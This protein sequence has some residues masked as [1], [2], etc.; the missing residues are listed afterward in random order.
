[1]PGWI[2]TGARG[3][4]KTLA[5][6]AKIKEYALRGRP[7]ATNLDLYLEKLLPLDNTAILYRLPD[8]PALA[9][10][11]L[12]PLAYDRSY[13]GEDMNGLLVLDE[14]GTW[15]NSRSWNDK[16]R[17]A[18]MNWL[19]LSRKYHWDIILL[20]QDYEMIDAQLRNTICEHWV[21]SS[22]LDKVKIPYLAPLLEFIGFNAFMPRIHR[23]F[24]FYGYDSR[25]KP[26]DLWTYS[27]TDFYYGYD[28]NQLFLD[29]SSPA[30][31]HIG[32]S[33]YLPASYLSGHQFITKAQKSLEQLKK[34][35]TKEKEVDMAI[36]KG[37]DNSKIKAYML[38]AFLVAFLAWRFSSGINLKAFSSASP[39]VA[40]PTA[41]TNT[42]PLAAPV[43]SPVSAPSPPL[44]TASAVPVPQSSF[45]QAVVSS[46]SSSA[47]SSPP[48]SA[49]DVANFID[50][51]LQTTRP[52]LSWFVESKVTRDFDGAVEF[53]QNDVL[54]ERFKISELHALGVAM[55]RTPYGFNLLYRTKTYVVPWAMSKPSNPAN[56]HHAQTDRTA[57]KSVSKPKARYPFFPDEDGGESSLVTSD[58]S[59]TP[60]SAHYDFK[61][62][63]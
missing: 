59:S 56:Q 62:H 23:Y 53:Y 36:K 42:T 51:L 22:R 1:M 31:V 19:F 25:Q 9:D 24:V 54:V 8:K 21:V 38:V 44:P 5:A 17:L 29:P 33:T 41:P 28:T 37:V 52:R 57:V 14:L 46:A 12:L 4:G 43:S 16:T 50:D 7:V 15:L 32:L 49:P 2:I 35:Y 27:G 18:L 11:E 61:G 26:V 6:V 40:S 58:V 3:E 34:Q 20:A 47:S 48:S 63:R 39:S 10:F 60:V 55:I 45:S 30:V 13:K